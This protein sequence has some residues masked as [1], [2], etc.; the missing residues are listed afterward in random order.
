MIFV[1]VCA[2][3]KGL[4]HALE[5]WLQSPACQNGQFLIAGE[6]IPCLQTQVGPDVSPSQRPRARPP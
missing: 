4:H 3:R 6:F 2:V 1:G 5:A